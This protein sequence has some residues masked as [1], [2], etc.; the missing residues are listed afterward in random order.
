[1]IRSPSGVSVTVLDVKRDPFGAAKAA[2]KAQEQAIRKTLFSLERKAA[3]FVG[4]PRL[5]FFHTESS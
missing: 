2:S 1:M 5:S 4:L 3:M